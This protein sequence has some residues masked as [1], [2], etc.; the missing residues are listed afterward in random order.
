MFAVIIDEVSRRNGLINKF[1]GDGTLAIFGAPIRALLPETDA[2]GAARAIAHRLANEV[3]ECQAAIGVAAGAVLAGNVG[4]FERFEYTVIGEPVNIAA[5]LCELAKSDP[6]RVLSSAE[7][8]QASAPDESQH[9]ILGRHTVLRAST[10]LRNWPAPT[11]APP[12]P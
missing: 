9:W 7:T 10:G 6:H 2:L 5:R 3:P 1:Q 11:T 8:V 4:A 12:A